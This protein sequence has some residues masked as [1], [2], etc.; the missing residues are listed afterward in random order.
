MTNTGTH[1]HQWARSVR[2]SQT[3]Q[4]NVE[5]GCRHCLTCKKTMIPIAF[6]IWSMASPNYQERIWPTI[7][8]RAIINAIIED[9]S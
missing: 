3:L 4:R 9:W 6:D 7:H 1:T 5:L 8:Y 2:Y